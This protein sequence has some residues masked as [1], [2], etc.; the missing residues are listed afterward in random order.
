MTKQP[1]KKINFSALK[2]LF[3]LLREDYSRLFLAF[4]TVI[5]TTSLSL[6]A[7]YI[8][9]RAIDRFVSVG[10]YKGVFLSAGILV[11][12]Y[13]ITFG[14]QYAQMNLVGGVGLRVLFRLRNAIFIKLQVLPI[15]F[16]NRQKA[17][18]LIS[19]IN[20]DTD[21]LNSFFS[22]TLVRFIGGVFMIIGSGI[23]ILAIQPKLGLATLV[24][25]L[26]ILLVTRGLSSWVKTRNLASLQTTGALSGEVQE[27]LDNFKVIAAFHRRDYFVS[28]FVEM[29]KA[30]FTASVQTGLANGVFSPLYDA[31]SAMAALIVIT[32]GIYLI[33]HDQFTIGLLLSFLL[34]VERFYMPL[35]Q[36]ATLW[37]S[38]QQALAGWERVSMILENSEEL[39]IISD[40]RTVVSD[41]AVLEFRHVHFRYSNGKEVLHDA[42]FSLQAGKTYA[43]VGPTGGGKTTTASLM[44]R[45]FDPVEGHILLQGKDIRSY[46]LEERTQRIGFILQEPFL[47]HGTILENLFFGNTEYAGKDEGILRAVLHDH[48]F[49][50]LLSRFE[51]GG[52][53]TLTA[54][55]TN[56][57]LGQKQLI[58]FMRAVL[59]RPDILILDEA[60]ANIDTVTE[61]LLQEIVDKLPSTSTKVIIAHRLNTIQNADEI[62]FV[63]G[64]EITA[65]GSFENALDLLMHGKRQS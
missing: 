22:E 19:R 58:A 63:N 13:A 46:S 38:F 54:A 30:N 45:L 39:P 10:D 41:P 17:G 27:S 29:N 28:R 31:L 8:F 34:Y 48:G 50:G 26:I 43:L 44:A 62:F 1:T 18:D 24:P 5:V 9:G 60:T 2:K 47:F 33:S 42:H 14:F 65:A 32:Y 51:R 55:A 52:V 61:K 7:P 4:M 64:A 36:L 16:F 11:V 6:L 15:A 49:D 53:L 57:S 56:L 40:N 25:A 12:A 23:F 37:S 59:R 21:K 20:N 35:R 3:V